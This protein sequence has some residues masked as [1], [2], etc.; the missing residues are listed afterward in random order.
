M[1]LHVSRPGGHGRFRCGHHGQGKKCECSFVRRG[2][3][4]CELRYIQKYCIYS[5]ERCHGQLL[6][7]S[8]HPPAPHLVGSQDHCVLVRRGDIA[9]RTPIRLFNKRERRKRITH[10]KRRQKTNSNNKTEGPVEH[11][12]TGDA[13]RG[14]PPRLCCGVSGFLFGRIANHGCWN[15]VAWR[16]VALRRSRKTRIIQTLARRT[17]WA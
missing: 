17:R 4:D 14:A 1:Y 9:K 16:R 11:T 15:S 6:S 12:H 13:V 3:R 8:P 10:R 5:A 7:V 2:D